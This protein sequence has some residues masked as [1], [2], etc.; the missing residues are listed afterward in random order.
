[1]SS[2]FEANTLAILQPPATPSTTGANEDEELFS[3]LTS[4]Q[5]E[6]FLFLAKEQANFFQR[7]L[8]AYKTT[9]R[10]LIPSLCICD[11][12]PEDGQPDSS[13]ILYQNIADSFNLLTD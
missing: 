1:M 10:I 6:D 3:C 5:N 7:I 2:S 4:N 9:N 12:T 8:P 13:Q 11:K